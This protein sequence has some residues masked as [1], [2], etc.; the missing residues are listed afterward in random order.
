M[1]LTVTLY[2]ILILISG[3]EKDKNPLMGVSSTDNETFWTPTAGPY[4]GSVIKMATNSSTVMYAATEDFG[5]FISTDGGKLWRLCTSTKNWRW[6]TDVKTGIQGQVLV[7]SLNEEGLLLSTD[8]GNNWT[9]VTPDSIGFISA[10]GINDKGSIFIDS[11]GKIYVY[12]NETDNWKKA[13]IPQNSSI[14][15]SF[16]FNANGD[17]FAGTNTGILRSL[18][19]GVHW[20]KVLENQSINSLEI[21]N[22]GTIY[23]TLTSPSRLLLRSIDNGDTWQEV[24]GVYA[25]LVASNSMGDIYAANQQIIYIS[26]DNGNHWETIT[27]PA[28]SL[29]YLN[30]DPQDRIFAGF[31]GDGI[32]ISEDYGNSW[33]QQGVPLVWVNSLVFNAHNQLLAGTSRGIFLTT[34]QGNSWNKV[35]PGLSVSV[36]S[37]VRN[38]VNNSIFTATTTGLYRSTDDGISW[39]QLTDGLPTLPSTYWDLAVNSRGEIFALNTTEIYRSLNNGNN[40]TKLFNLPPSKS[41]L[42][43]SEDKIYIGQYSGGLYISSDSG[44]SW[45][46]SGAGLDSSVITLTELFESST[47]DIYAATSYGLFRLDHTTQ[48]F[49]KIDS[50]PENITSITENSNH[51]I[52]ISSI[53]EGIM[54]SRDSCSTWETLEDGLNL[55]PHIGNYISVLIC[56]KEN[57]IFAG[58]SRYGVYRS[59]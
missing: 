44:E 9:R 52:L 12:T 55:D 18:D 53:Y 56:D 17:A 40:W 25:Y 46:Y 15:S 51:C 7:G 33:S 6:I 50:A 43:D 28:N 22:N 34:D 4:G 14:V 39:D 31:Y 45:V 42:I 38:K 48:K 5:L 30:I 59:N 24:N 20:I 13:N 23:A 26:K 16:A 58:S 2:I 11:F 41:V 35:I 1:K 37:I 10:I 32:F 21:V 19:N 29:A 54:I 49:Q 36:Y 27:T 8:K 47:G 57:R 3:C